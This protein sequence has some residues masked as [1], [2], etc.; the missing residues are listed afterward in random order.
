MVKKIRTL[1]VGISGVRGIVG[2]SLTPT[3]ITRFAQAYGTYTRGGRIVIGS[4]TRVSGEMVKYGV[5]SGLLSCGCEIIDLGICPVPTLQL[6]LTHLQCDGGI[7]ITASHNPIEWNALKFFSRE[8]VYL[9]NE[10]F[11]YL[12]DIYHQG[13]F[14][15]VEWQEYKNIIHNT[16]GIN[17]HIK[18]ILDSLHNIEEIRRKHFRVVL[19]ACNGAGAVS[20]PHLLKELNCDIVPI[21]IVP[22]G[23][24]PRN[25]E[26]LPENLAQASAAVKQ[27]NADIGFAQ[28]ADADRLSIIDEKGNPVSEEFTVV[29]VIN[30]FLRRI[31]NAN[32]TKEKIV[33]VNLSTTKT[34][35]DIAAKY[36][37]KVIRSKVGEINVVE[38]MKRNNAIVGGEGN[39]G[40]IIPQV[41][42]GRDSLSAMAYILSELAELN[43]KASELISTFPQYKMVK[44]KITC[45][46]DKIWTIINKTKELYSQYQ[47]DTTDG[48]KII[49]GDSWLH[50][51]PSNTEPVI[52]IVAEAP[53]QNDVSQIVTEYKKKISIYC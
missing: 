11:S 53:T 45:P 15:K 4:D 36:N 32:P 33:V 2:E 17:V 3:V 18:R 6:M 52:R 14:R 24:F 44:E 12:V 31:T 27:T 48:I 40:V 38:T 43:C 49:F 21:N 39:G 51:R 23:I 22:N 8:G 35:D 25:P 10:Q 5:F 42:Y 34:V 19:D 30:S 26:P 50:V 29:I 37:A 28:D 7:M 1:K 41:V 46:T 9:N 13:A 16:E 20:A 47:M